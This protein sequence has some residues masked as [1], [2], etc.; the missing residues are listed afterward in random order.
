MVHLHRK[1]DG[2]RRWQEEGGGGRKERAGGGWKEGAGGR[3]RKEEAD[4]GN[5]DFAV[6]SVNRLGGFGQRVCASTQHSKSCTRFAP[7][8][9]PDNISHRAVN[10]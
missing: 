5:E 10:L 7:D 8:T 1:E 9:N 3:R 4:E 2:V 6:P